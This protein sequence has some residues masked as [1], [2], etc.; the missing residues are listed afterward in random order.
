MASSKKALG[1]LFG[2]KG[3]SSISQGS[4][5]L[6]LQDLKK[7]VNQVN[8]NNKLLPKVELRFDVS[9]AIKSINKLQKA[10]NNLQKQTKNINIPNG[11]KGGAKSS[12][13]TQN[14]AAAKKYFKEL[15]TLQKAAART[16]DVNADKKTGYI[17]GINGNNYQNHYAYYQKLEKDYKR[18]AGVIDDRNLSTSQKAQTLNLTINEYEELS[19]VIG[20]LQTQAGIAFDKIKIDAT[21]AW[22]KQASNVSDSI[23][24]VYDTISKDPAVKDL[25]DDILKMTKQGSGNVEELKQKFQEFNLKARQTGA[26]IET[27]GQKFKKA[28][29]NQV[30]SALASLITVDIGQVLKGVYDNVVA[31]DDAV[32]NLQ[33]ASGKSRTETKALVK[34]YAALAKQL[35]ATTAEV[36][37][38][39]DTWL[40]QGYSA[41]EAQTLITN[42]MMLSKLGQIESEEAATA[43][44]SAMKGYKV[45]V[46]DSV[47]IVDKLTAVDMEAAASAG[48]IATAMAETAAGA[49]LAGVSMDKLIGYLAVVKEVTQDA[50]ESVGTFFRTLFARMGNIKVGKYVDEDGESLN[51]VETVLGELG[52]KLRESNNEFRNFSDVL[53]EVGRKWNDF[54]EV[55]K[56]AVASALAG[57]KQREKLIVLMDNYGTSLQYAAT[58]AESAGTATQKYEA[59]TE[60]V[61]GAIQGLKAAF[62]ELSLTSL[63][64]GLV[65]DVVNL[66]TRVLG[67]LTGVMSVVDAMGGLKTV[68]IA[69]SGIVLSMKYQKILDVLK[70]VKGGF[71]KIGDSLLE[72]IANFIVARVEGLKGADSLRAAFSSIKVGAI[73]AKGAIIGVTIAVTALVAA[74][75]AYLSSREKS[76]TVNFSNAES[77]AESA[78]KAEEE[79]DS[80]AAL[81]ERYEQL[82]Q[83]S[84]GTWDASAAEDIRELQSQITKL[85]G[86]QADNIDIVNGKLADQKLILDNIAKDKLEDAYSSARESVVDAALAYSDK[87]DLDYAT[88]AGIAKYQPRGKFAVSQSRS[89]ID[90]LKSISKEFGIEILEHDGYSG[91]SATIKFD[92]GKNM[93][94]FVAQ[95][96]H[97]SMA[98]SS[99]SRDDR[100][101]ET[102][103]GEAVLRALSAYIS[104]YESVYTKYTSALELSE[105]IASK[106]AQWERGDSKSEGASGATVSRKEILGIFESVQPAYDAISDALANLREG[107]LLT[108]DSLSSLFELEKDGKIGGVETAKLITKAADGYHL[109]A[110]AL[111]Q[112]VNSMVEA[113][114]A[115]TKVDFATQQDANN[116]IANLENLIRVLATLAVTQD[117]ATNA[118]DAYRD[119][120]ES[121]KDELNDGLD[122]YKELIDLRKD[123]LE[124]YADELEYQKELEKKQQNVASLRAKLAVARLD[125]SAAGQARVRALEEKLKEAQED[126][127][128][129]TLEHAIDEIIGGLDS[130]Y[131]EYENFIKGELEKIEKQLEGI[132]DKDIAI[133]SESIKQWTD[134][135]RDAI[136]D[137][138]DSRGA[139]EDSGHNIGG[140][141]NSG[142]VDKFDSVITP[143]MGSESVWSSTESTN[144]QTMNISFDERAM[145]SK[146]KQAMNEDIRTDRERNDGTNVSSIRNHYEAFWDAIM[147]QTKQGKYD[148]ALELFDKIMTMRYPMLNMYHAGG[149]VGGVPTLANNEEFAKL[150]EGEFVSTPSQIKNFMTRTLPQLT[151][152]NSSGGHEFHAPLVEIKCESVTSESIPKLKEIVDEAVGEI[153][154]CL[155]GGMSR[156]G[157]KRSVK[158]LLT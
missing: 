94:D 140:S 18:L 79:S 43:L 121:Q 139:P 20:E 84:A 34:E 1:I 15:K 113:E 123:L 75:K 92:F 158:K 96:Q 125:N 124:S 67:V 41:K 87:V 80:L 135:I 155:D 30:R 32:V 157:Y 29:A 46:E 100:Y 77:H 68:L 107:G 90:E 137:I 62:E 37:A 104:E 149:F 148:V 130:Q 132:G 144:S 133:D 42:S 71:V 7:I 97:A 53:D 76:I 106:L 23:H 25:A 66:G 131:S 74:Y 120:L 63:D 99:L 110:D 39:A 56:N 16:A 61:T 116:A 33:I 24:R 9:D 81:I 31:L 6:I 83:S 118:A 57:T 22:Q 52:I 72:I 13:Y 51:D 129:Y 142:P 35:K 50:D 138:N 156:T 28:F 44:T 55:D 105:D 128:D 38:S 21:A 73:S 11:G 103:E 145:L 59:Y 82:S 86:E 127:E 102:P 117:D 65:I 91:S 108:A 54:S 111:E 14:L 2:V 136:K 78:K 48:G 85:V 95:Y 8:N 17:L 19:Q 88:L 10:L 115:A 3:G 146:L 89:Y 58:A 154:R 40:R 122:A 150:L 141:I 152:F 134:T 109:A 93:S 153:K 45:A 5:A 112:Y 147:E 12:V 60:G 64:S 98:K 47:S 49:G 119:S 26:D 126:L 114:I 69:V 101:K 27:W 143:S 70:N 4:G 151:S 36:A